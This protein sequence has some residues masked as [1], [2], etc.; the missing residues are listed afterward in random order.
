V[1]ERLD[2]D[3][4]SAAAGERANLVDCFRRIEDDVRAELFRER[5][6][7]RQRLEVMMRP[8]PRMRAAAVAQR[9]T[10]PCAK[11]ATL[12]PKR[13]PEFSIAPKSGGHDVGGEGTASS[14]T[15]VRDLRHVELGGRTT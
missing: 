3:V 6:A 8:A 15:V 1:T 11:I 2:G 13:S 12:S 10:G 9:P 14:F 4:D 5:D 7:R